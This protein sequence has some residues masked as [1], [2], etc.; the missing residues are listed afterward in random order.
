MA[1]EFINARIA[2][3]EIPVYRGKVG[4]AILDCMGHIRHME[5]HQQ[6]KGVV[7]IPQF[8]DDSKLVLYLSCLIDLPI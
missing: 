6:F 8:M 1:F 3:M 4:M 2:P 7:G 5:Q